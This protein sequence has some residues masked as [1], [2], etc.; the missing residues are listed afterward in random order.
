MTA[1]G[2]IPPAGETTA[3]T[4][5]VLHGTDGPAR[6]PRQNSAPHQTASPAA[7]DQAAHPAAHPA[8]HSA[9][10]PAHGAPTA[11]DPGLRKMIGLAFALTAIVSVM[12]I[13]LGLPAVK[14]GAHEVPIG[15]SAPTATAQSLTTQ[16]NGASAD[17]DAF[18][19][20]TYVDADA[21]REAIKERDVYGGIV[22]AADGVQIL[23]ASAGSPAIATSLSALAGPLGEATQQPVSVVDVVALPATDPRGT[24]LA[25]AALAL[26]MS[27]M[28]PAI[29]LSR[30]FA[31]RF[32]AGLGTA[33]LA[34]VGIGTAVSLL[35][36]SP[37]HAVDGALWPVAGGLA[38]GSIAISWTLLSLNRLVGP[39]G[40]YLGAAI[41]VLLGTP[42]SGLA[43]APELLP[44]GLGT[45]GQ[46]LPP[47]ANATLL[48]S[49]AYFDGAGSTHALLVLLAWLTLAIV[50]ATLGHVRHSRRFPKNG[51]HHRN[52]ST[53]QHATAKHS[54]QDAHPALEG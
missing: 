13:A 33:A 15:I 29:L 11:A 5:R 17:G 24:G 21:L 3:A 32:W 27:G 10:H 4:A 39:V 22:V 23:T 41:M 18:A 37:F 43:S 1:Q 20:D 8:A 26:T 31:S 25:S 53:G 40:L 19:V 2:P 12:L 50:L 9:A 48:R 45:L 46:L 52:H 36:H 51:E 38:L 44:S 28:L 54:T 42:L 7:G 14:S 35:L 30:A 16:L 6:L 49:N 34:A 47:G